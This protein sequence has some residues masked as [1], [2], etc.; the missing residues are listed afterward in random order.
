MTGE[1]DFF[2]L[3][4]HM[5]PREIHK[6]W[7]HVASECPYVPSG[8]DHPDYFTLGTRLEYYYYWRWMVSRGEY[9]KTDRGYIWLL[10]FE[11]YNVDDDPE[12]NYAMM[13]ALRDNYA[14]D[15]DVLYSFISKTIKYYGI[16]I[17][18]P[19]EDEPDMPTYFRGFRICQILS[20]PTYVPLSCNDLEALYKV[21][22][23]AWDEYRDRV[24]DIVSR[25]LWRMGSMASIVDKGTNLL[26]IIPEEAVSP[27]G[28]TLFHSK[29]EPLHLKYIDVFSRKFR[30]L[31]GPVVKAV[32]LLLS[33]PRTKAA[34]EAFD[35][36]AKNLGDV[37]IEEIG[38]DGPF[39]PPVRFGGGRPFCVTKIA[40]FYTTSSSNRIP[41]PQ[42]DGSWPSHRFPLRMRE[43][44]DISVGSGFVSESTFREP[45]YSRMRMMEMQSYIRWRE[46]SASGR[47]TIP[48]RGYA[49][50]MMS[51]L[52]NDDS[53]TPQENM[54]MMPMCCDVLHKMGNSAGWDAMACYCLIHDLVPTG[55]DLSRD[56][57]PM[58]ALRRILVSK[59]EFSALG[60]GGLNKYMGT[61]MGPSDHRTMVIVLNE[62]YRN[63]GFGESLND[64]GNPVDFT[65]Y[66]GFPCEHPF[67]SVPITTPNGRARRNMVNA[68]RVTMAIVRGDYDGSRPAG[69]KNEWIECIRGVLDAMHRRSVMEA[70][71]EVVLDAGE[72]SRAENDLQVVKGLMSVEDSDDDTVPVE[73]PVEEIS[74]EESD[75]LPGPGDSWDVFI[76]SLNEGQRRYLSAALEGTVKK[77]RMEKTINEI[78]L[79][80][81]G[82]VVVEDGRVLE[83]YL[84]YISCRLR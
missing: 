21:T 47:Q 29:E 76:A 7:N 37:V 61:G 16:R 9:P 10:L 2:R 39:D 82:D 35:A 41:L 54:V 80:E 59:G 45:A 1:S 50:L 40:G 56:S 46:A 5:N 31:V 4:G 67:W 74:V 13:C 72:L 11:L 42:R 62:L 68:Y 3:E 12:E 66:M 63:A 64:E 38:R 22:A 79:R 71:P 14:G 69:F 34:K 49:W 83:E 78:A 23:K 8:R 26:S 58:N 81:T 51:E 73:A 6:R 20:S 55:M 65:L 44:S 24:S 27:V 77:V 75:T 33:K 25:V 28:L 84:D 48:D 57:T 19:V 60:I 18:K 15:D 53:R 30:Q 36:L 70:L 32:F 43:Y 52:L 17:G